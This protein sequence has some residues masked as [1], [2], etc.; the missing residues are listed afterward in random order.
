MIPLDY[1]MYTHES[2]RAALKA[3]RAVPGFPALL[4]A[5]MN[6]WDERQQRILNMSSRI[7]L[8]KDQMKKYCDL[9]PPICEKLG[10]EVPELYLEMNVVPNAFT[11]GDTN[12]YIV[13]TSGLLRTLP[14]EL[15]RT[16]LAHECGHI[17]CHH[18]L[19]LTMGRLL[20]EGTGGVLSS[21]HPLGGL[22]TLPL[23]VAFYYWMRCS[24]FSAD[25]AAVLCDGTDR[26]MQEVCMRLAGWDRDI[27]ADASLEAFLAQA[28]DY[29][30]MISGSKWNKT[31]EFLIMSGATHPLM[32]VR[33]TE[34]RTWFRSQAC[35]DLLS[36]QAISGYSPFAGPYRIAEAAPGG[37]A[38]PAEP[39]PAPA[40][41]GR[42]SI[43]PEYGQTDAAE[44]NVLMYGRVNTQSRAVIRVSSVSRA[45]ALPFGDAE[46]V[47]ARIRRELSDDQGIISA[48]C[49]TA[50]GGGRYA[51]AI[52][53]TRLAPRG[54]A[55]ELRW[56]LETGE[57]AMAVHGT[58][59][60]IGAPGFRE[61]T[62]KGQL[63]RTQQGADA[64]ALETSWRRDPYDPG[65]TE[66][67]LMN[68]SEQPRYDARFPLHPLTEARAFQRYLAEHN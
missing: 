2:D 46:A 33:A 5:F 38:A 62:V 63:K 43:P 8:G 24:E 12:P 53:K 22:L 48:A 61:A 56:H 32:A 68:E 21:A 14:D 4:R 39:A 6:I 36:V 42:V 35:R 29:R 31:L 58:F 57:G 9:L 44:E 13:I 37:E 59:R 18:V 67:F 49:G 19:Y 41:S 47:I 55:Y 64:A 34:C 27:Q 20:L 26:K 54:T 65:R 50:A 3:L 25:R 7:R 16:V 30:E 15:I 60:E 28:A 11:G 52:V 51:C 45:E 66:G 23:Q 40:F 1:E 17:A 10:I